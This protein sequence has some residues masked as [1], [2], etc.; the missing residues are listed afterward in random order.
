[1]GFVNF[2]R[3]NQY[4]VR[5]ALGPAAQFT[6][7][8]SGLDVDTG[9]P[10]SANQ[11]KTVTFVMSCGAVTDGTIDFTVEESDVAGSGYTAIPASRVYGNLTP[12]FTS[13]TDDTAVAIS[14]KPAKRY[15]RINTVETVASSGYFM[16]GVA[17]MERF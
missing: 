14:V 13:A 7:A 9:A 17:V 10:G 8:Q 4:T 6:T 1:M 5:R 16:S 15:V 3:N 2:D 11:A 12:G